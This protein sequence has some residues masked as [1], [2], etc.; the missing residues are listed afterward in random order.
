MKPTILAAK[1]SLF[2]V[3]CV[4]AIFW[5]TF[6]LTPTGHTGGMSKHRLCDIPRSNLHGVDGWMDGWV[7]MTALGDINLK[8]D[9]HKI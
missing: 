1:T 7:V 9:D 8:F 6:L 5:A 2:Q 3:K 4:L